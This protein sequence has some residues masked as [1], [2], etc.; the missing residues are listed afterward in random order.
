MRFFALYLAFTLAGV[1]LGAEPKPAATPPGKEP[2][3]DG[4]TL[5]QWIALAKDKGPAMRIE[6]VAAWGKIGLR[7][8]PVLTE[9]LEFREAGIP[10]KYDWERE[11]DG[12]PRMT[13][14]TP[15]DKDPNYS[16]RP[17]WPWG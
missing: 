13:R 15:R 14:S 3:Y 7:A 11:R 12:P 4:K 9:L 8:I 1:S 16:P 2:S 6:A 10:V 5:S 17:R